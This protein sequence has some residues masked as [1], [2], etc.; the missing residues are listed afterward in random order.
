MPVQAA[1]PA[2]GPR[3]VRALDRGFDHDRTGRS[4]RIGG[5]RAGRR[6][7]HACTSVRSGGP[8]A[9]ARSGRL[10]SKRPRVRPGRVRPGRLRPCRV[11]WRRSGG[12]MLPLPRSTLEPPTAP[13][14]GKRRPRARARRSGP[15]CGPRHAAPPSRRPRG[16]CACPRSDAGRLPRRR[17]S[18]RCRRLPPPAARRLS[19]ALRSA[20]RRHWVR[21]PWRSSPC[22][23][24]CCASFLARCGRHAD[25]SQRDA[26]P[27]MVV[28]ASTSRLRSTTST[29]RRTSAMPIRPRSGR[30][31]RPAPPAARG[32]DVLPHGGRRARD[33]GL[34]R[35]PGAGPR[36]RR[37][38]PT[39][40]PC[41]GASCRRG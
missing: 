5:S 1:A 20:E 35:R 36:R 27:I 34:P 3:A 40:S 24:G 31:A 11:G 7:A 37:S 39:G 19:S 22:G 13:Q 14:T 4:A 12:R 21:S 30:H 32:R 15:G 29:R 10:R 25:G 23:A 16:R 2:V 9:R 38:T 26:A 8:F 17:R 41:P 33:E 28:C 18:R 6:P